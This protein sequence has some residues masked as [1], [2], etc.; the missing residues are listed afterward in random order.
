MSDLSRREKDHWLDEKDKREGLK[1]LYYFGKFILGFD[2]EEQPHREVCEFVQSTH[3]LTLMLLPRGSFKTTIISQIYPVWL[4]MKN[5]N[6][7]ILLDSVVLKNSERNL[8]VIKSILESNERL[9][10]LFGDHVNAKKWTQNEITSKLRVNYKLRDPTIGTTSVDTAEI[11]THWDYIIPDDL[12]NEDNSRNKDQIAKIYEH[13]RLLFSLLDP[14][15]FMRIVG[16]RWAD[17]DVYGIIMERHKDVLHMTRRA[18]EPDGTLYFPSRLTHKALEK[19]KGIEGIEMFSAQYLNNPVPEGENANFRKEWFIY[20]EPPKDIGLFITAD[21][22]IGTGPNADF[23][24]LAVGG[25]S[26]NNN[27]YVVDYKF[28]RWHPYEAIEQI[29][30]LYD[31]YKGRVKAI[32]IEI[33][34]FQK[35]F[36]FA[37]DVEMRKRGKFINIIELRHTKSKND[38][39]LALQPRYKVNAVIHAPW[40]RDGELEEQLL[41]HPRARHDDVADAVASLLEVVTPRSMRR[42]KKKVMNRNINSIDRLGPEFALYRQ[43]RET[44]GAKGWNIRR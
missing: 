35:M 13:W 16:T 1:S 40:M 39:I 22:A 19:I 33:N 37:F 8:A 14:G 24:A 20:A 12:H 15:G 34:A 17:L 21:P 3:P 32:G 11:G 43:Y 6:V 9:R 4:M 5:P 36:K 30:A 38:R 41:R 26:R 23:F 10:Y 42:P 27:L 31:K 28:A 18:V 25:L 7:R 44:E 2:L 29:F